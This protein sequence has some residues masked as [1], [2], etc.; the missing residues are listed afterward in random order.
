MI[1]YVQKAEYDFLQIVKDSNIIRLQNAGPVTSDVRDELLSKNYYI[2]LY[3]QDANTF[4]A[5]QYW[6]TQNILPDDGIIYSSL[7]AGF[8]QLANGFYVWN[9]YDSAGVFAI[10]LIPVKWNYVVDNNYLDNNFVDN[11]Q[12]G[13]QYDIFPGNAKNGNVQSI[14]NIPLF[15]LLQKST[16]VVIKD[17]I[18]SVC[19]R[20]VAALLVLLFVHLCAVYIAVKSRLRYAILFL[21]AMI[22]FLRVLAYLFPIPLNLRQL[23]LFDPTIYGSN[24]I[25]RSLGDLLINSMLFVWVIIFARKQLNE[26]NIGFKLTKSYYKWLLVGAGSFIMLAATFIAIHVIRSL[27]L[28]SQISFDVINFFSLNIYSVIG[29][30]VLCC[31]AVGFY[32]LCQLI[33]YFIK[34]F[35]PLKFIEL[36]LVTTVLGLLLLT[37]NINIF[38]GGMELYS[39]GWLLLFLF[40]LNTS[41]LNLFTTRIVSSKLVFWIFFFSI[42]MTIIIV[43]E[44]TGKEIR[45][46][47]HYAEVLANKTNPASQTML[48]SMLIDYRLDFLTDNFNRLKIKASNQ[49]LKDSL[50]NNNT[51]GYTNRY[52]TRIFSYD[53]NEKPLFNESGNISYNQLNSILNTQAKPTA[54]AGLS[55]YDESYDRFNYISKKVIR[56]TSGKLLGSIIILVSPRK[57]QPDMPFPDMFSKGSTASIENSSVYAFAVYSNNRL[58]NSHNDYPFSTSMPLLNFLGNEYKLVPNKNYDELWYRAGNNKFIV[59]AKENRL[60]LESLTL[61]SYFFCAFLLLT[62]L[63]WLLTVFISS[64]LNPKSC[65]LTGN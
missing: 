17:N 31:I 36:Y 6:N 4:P 29:F 48:N 11:P 47:Q 35:F 34:P 19:F 56:D 18:F 23:E 59:I 3:N 42:S 53:E 16:G 27:V 9:K 5:L 10:A 15:H 22:I 65:A 64:R 52:D 20:I 60:S 49:F 8:A 58:V 40:F 33:L 43:V 57:I 62:A 61:F 39:V 12:T 51:S 7:K 2:F 54:V 38:E 50:V 14:H 1:G 24:F 63:F 25:L 37:L 21:V 30:V 55:Y 44:N 46:R 13:L 26:K 28:D 45:S 41:Y 32:F